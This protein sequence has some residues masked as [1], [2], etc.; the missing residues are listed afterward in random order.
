VA[1]DAR[2][3]RKFYLDFPADL[4]PGEPLTFIL[5]LHGGGS[6]GGWQRQYF[7]AC[8]YVDRHALVVAT[9][10]AATAEPVRRWVGEAD[11]EHLQ[12]VAES[13]FERFGVE[14]IKSFWLAGHSQGGMTSFRLLGTPWF[15]DRV[16]GF[17]SLSGGRIGTAPRAEGAGRPRTEQERAAEGAGRPPGATRPSGALPDADFSF[18]YAI[19]EHEIA[20]LP[21]SSPWAEKYAAGP[22]RQRPDVVDVEPGQVHDGRFD[23]V[24]RVSTKQWGLLP[25]PGTAKVWIYPEAKD[26]RVIADVVRIDKGHTEGLEPKVTE[27]LL[28]LIVAAPGGK[29]GVRS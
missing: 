26:G 21:D 16:D 3:G 29:L 23:G 10:T 2:T 7:P 19:G 22:R 8:D 15:A 24:T 4:G 12:A 5:N 6:S 17:L 25:R 27:K 1:I 13:V 28:E 18:I 14:N 9:P 20:S 11:D